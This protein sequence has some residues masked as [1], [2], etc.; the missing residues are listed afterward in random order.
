M[1][2]NPAYS[3]HFGFNTCQLHAG[4]EPDPTTGS[5]AT[6]IYQTTS[7]IFRDTE[8]ASRLFALEEGV[9]IYT[10][11]MN[12]TSGVFEQRMANPE[13]GS[14]ALAT[15]S[16]LGVQTTAILALCEQ[17]GPSCGSQYALRRYDQPVCLDLPTVWD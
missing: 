7:Y 8:H 14:G 15:S 16:G 4:Q 9:N 2:D 3:R 6:P 11:I 13:G 1:S 12:P 10:R 17:G 5:R